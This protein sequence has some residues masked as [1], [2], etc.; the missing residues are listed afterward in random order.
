M[1]LNS[2][3]AGS[4][5][6]KVNLHKA[7]SNEKSQTQFVN[8]NYIVSM[9]ETKESEKRGYSLKTDKTDNT[10]TFTTLNMSNGSKLEINGDLES[11]AKKFNE[12]GQLNLI[13]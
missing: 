9:E 10:K 4:S 3:N 12:A 11:N 13:A 6:I 1:N 7:S 8:P 2:I 5:F